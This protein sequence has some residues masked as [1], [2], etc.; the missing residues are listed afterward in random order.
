[1]ITLHC[2]H[3]DAHGKK[4]DIVV[5]SIVNGVLMVYCTHHNGEQHPPTPI[6]YSDLMRLAEQE[7]TRRDQPLR[8]V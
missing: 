8:S 7:R 3:R 5:A 1:M 6:V 2:Q 4:C